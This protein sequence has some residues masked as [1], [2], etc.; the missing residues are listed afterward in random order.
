MSIGQNRVVAVGPA[1][2]LR[3]AL[4]TYLRSVP[5]VVVEAAVA[6]LEEVLPLLQQRPAHSVI[7]DADL[8]G[9]FMAQLNQVHHL[10][11]EINLIALV[12]RPQ[13]QP[14]ALAAGATHALLKG[15]L[16]ERLRQA[17]TADPEY[18]SRPLIQSP[19]RKE[20]HP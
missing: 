13:E 3:S 4:L 2:I 17:L 19:C 9:N 18:S 6:S 5:G 15:F 12:N 10:H 7:L 8:N 16:D 14:A 11:P 1:G 20:I